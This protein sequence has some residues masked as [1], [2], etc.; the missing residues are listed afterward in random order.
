MKGKEKVLGEVV[1]EFIGYNL[2]RCASILTTRILFKSLYMCTLEPICQLLRLFSVLSGNQT[3]KI[4]AKDFSAAP[5]YYPFNAQL[6]TL[7]WYF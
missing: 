4:T 6:I 7:K 5:I 3:G 2:S 1:L